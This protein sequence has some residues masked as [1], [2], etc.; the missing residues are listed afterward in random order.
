MNDITEAVVETYVQKAAVRLEKFLDDLHAYIHP[1]IEF[2]HHVDA[3]I[4]RNNRPYSGDKEFVDSKLPC[5]FSACVEYKSDQHTLVIRRPQEMKKHTD[6]N[7]PHSMFIQ[8]VM[9]Q[10]KPALTIQHPFRLDLV[11][12][13]QF[14]SQS[15]AIE[16]VALLA[17]FYRLYE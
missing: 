14:Y 11:E 2:A 13:Q 9:H 17:A 7:I 5:P 3:P 10:G 8:A 16:M 4:T 6:R 12:E 1:V 15:E